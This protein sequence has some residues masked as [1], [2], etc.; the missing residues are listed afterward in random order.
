[1]RKFCIALVA[2]FAIAWSSIYLYARYK[3]NA[4]IEQFSPEKVHISYDKLYVKVGIK[5]PLSIII[6]DIIAKSDRVI[7]HMNVHIYPTF[8]GVVTKV[9][10]K[11]THKQDEFF[12]P[13]TLSTK[14]SP[15]NNY[16][17]S[18]V[19]VEKAKFYINGSNILIKG[20]CSFSQGKMPLGGYKIFI[21]N[22]SK[23]LESDLFEGYPTILYKIKSI[24]D[25]MKNIHDSINVDYTEDG[26][27]IDGIPIENI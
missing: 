16:Y 22:T 14:L 18:E 17:L 11:A 21:S 20:G 2:I 19:N 6:K 4:L 8:G 13:L 9:E 23:L 25:N 7:C 5:H 15:S 3:T 1:M 26:I 10:I 12:V 27:I 24:L